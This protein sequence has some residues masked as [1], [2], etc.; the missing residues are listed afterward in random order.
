MREKA[1]SGNKDWTAQPVLRITGSSCGQRTRW[2]RMRLERV[3]AWTALRGRS[4]NGG[5]EH[6]VFREFACQWEEEGKTRHHFFF[7]F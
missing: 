1:R 3:E 7:F 2:G 6:G 4:G 5:S